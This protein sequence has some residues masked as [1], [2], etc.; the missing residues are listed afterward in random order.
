MK[1]LK[2]LGDNKYEVE[3]T[4]VE[5]K[6]YRENNL[7]VAHDYVQ[8]EGT[9][10]FRREDL[11][12]S[13]VAFNTSIQIPIK[14][15]FNVCLPFLKEHKYLQEYHFNDRTWTEDDKY[16]NP[17]RY[18]KGDKYPA[19]SYQNEVIKYWDGEQY[20]VAVA[21]HGEKHFNI[22]TLKFFNSFVKDKIDYK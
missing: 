13:D 3:I 21:L 11:S 20:M 17:P 12:I 19:Y 7:L 6:K 8:F 18:K 15:F 22:M 5:R 9:D 14:A 16:E 1:I 2:D 4:P 10:Y